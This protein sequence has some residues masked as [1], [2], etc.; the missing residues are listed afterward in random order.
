MIAAG[1]DGDRNHQLVP[2]WA[3]PARPSVPI[4]QVVGQG[5]GASD[6]P[7]I[8]QGGFTDRLAMTVLPAVEPSTLPW[9]EWEK[10]QTSF[11]TV[12]DCRREARVTKWSPNKLCE[13]PRGEMTRKASELGVFLQA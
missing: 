2:D 11:R 5:K 8:L 9:A 10:P 1:A 4:L 3:W 7:E 6:R 12:R 13:L